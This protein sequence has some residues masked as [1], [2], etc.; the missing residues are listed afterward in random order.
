MLH[1]YIK[2]LHT[3]S[4]TW[5]YDWLIL[6]TIPWQAVSYRGMINVCIYMYVY[7][8]SIRLFFSWAFRHNNNNNDNKNLSNMIHLAKRSKKVRLM[9]DGYISGAIS[10]EKC[11]HFQQKVVAEWSNAREWALW[12]HHQAGT[13]DEQVSMSCRTQWPPIVNCDLRNVLQ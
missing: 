13:W 7:M 6:V 3:A 9:W 5:S 10:L 11:T 1:V 12:L 2:S 8:Y 4:L